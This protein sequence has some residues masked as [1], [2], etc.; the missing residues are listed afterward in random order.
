[1]KTDVWQS[2]PKK[3]DGLLYAELKDI[4]GKSSGV[5]LLKNSESY[6]YQL[7]LQMNGQSFLMSLAE[8]EDR[9]KLVPVATDTDL[10]SAFELPES[11]AYVVTGAEYQTF[12]NAP[13]QLGRVGN[14]VKL[15]D[16]EDQLLTPVP[17]V[18][19]SS[20]F[21]PN[22]FISNCSTTQVG[23]Y[24]S[25][26]GFAFVQFFE[27]YFD[28]QNSLKSQVFTVSDIGSTSKP[29]QVDSESSFG[30][31]KIFE[32][33][34]PEIN[35]VQDPQ[36]KTFERSVIRE[37]VYKHVPLKGSG[38]TA[39]VLFRV[40]GVSSYLSSYQFLYSACE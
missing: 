33:L 14:E 34:F 12:F 6:G 25:S 35:P 36:E 28:P 27:N 1:M 22:T 18:N 17:T 38:L 4:P 32:Q 10:L 19:L 7:E 40:E 23:W 8:N 21:T 9:Y 39:R 15:L 11:G 13:I 26:S 2:D 3:W 37:V 24:G 20:Q 29:F 30:Q 31:P 5:D 16:P